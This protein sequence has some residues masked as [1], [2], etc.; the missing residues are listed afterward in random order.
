MPASHCPEFSFD[1][2]K[3]WNLHIKFWVCFSSPE[4]KAQASHCHS[5]PSIANLSVRRPGLTSTSLQPQKG[6][7]R[8]LTGSKISTSS[9]ELVFF[10]AIGTSKMAALVSD[11][12][13]QFSISPL[14]PVNRIQ[15]N[16]TGSK[17]STSPTKFMVFGS[18]EKQDDSPGL[19]FAEE[20]STSPLKPL[21][22]IQKLDRKVDLNVL[23]QV[24]VFR[25]DPKYRVSASDWLRHFRLLLWSRWMEFN[26]TW[27]EVRSQCSLTSFRAD[28][29]NK[30]A[31]L[32]SD[33]LRHFRPLI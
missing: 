20:F 14:K 17:I 7:Q 18:I 32:V 13:G 16:L 22:R 28:L 10:R 26:E 11:W 19:W 15:R 4:P 5:A 12:Q 9:I 33:W 2:N 8:N 21:N 24:C 31:T 29:K 23:N 6:I 27:Q 25:D 30:M 3:I 1:W